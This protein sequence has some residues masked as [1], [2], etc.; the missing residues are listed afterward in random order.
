MVLAGTGLM[1]YNEVLVKVENVWRKFP[2]NLA[3]ARRHGLRE[4]FRNLVGLPTQNGQLCS[5]EFWVLKDVSFSLER[6]E[7]IGI[8]GLNGAGKSTLLKMIAGLL[9]PSK[10]EVRVRGK[11]DSLIEL[12]TGF[13]PSLSG[14]ENIFI[15]CAFNGMSHKETQLLFDEIV[16][17]AELEEFIDMP[18]KSYS[19]GM[20]ARLGF[21]TAIF[22]QPDILVIDEVLSVGDFAFRQ[23][24]LDKMN[25]IKERTAILFV[26]HSFGTVRMFCDKGIVLDRGVK[27]FEGSSKD[28]IDTLV[29]RRESSELAKKTQQK[30]QK[31]TTP[32]GHSVFGAVHKNSDKIADVHCAWVDD[33][34]NEVSE[35]FR[36]DK[37]NLRYRFRLSYTPKNLLIGIPLW[38]SKEEL[39]TSFSS[40]LQEHTFAIDSDG[41][42]RGR[43]G[44]KAGFNS[45]KYHAV[46]AIHDGPEYIYR[47]MLPPL[48]ITGQ[49]PR[50]FG[51][52]RLPHQWM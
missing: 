26:S 12:G 7:S 3:V 50:L 6:G 52:I 2:R 39:V 24:C 43:L 17:F 8:L 41:W 13:H 29:S 21:A 18:V 19:T 32:G 20:H 34:G 38:N 9:L 48:V 10:G 37:I 14:R 27:V 36:T 25:K 28:A 35:F 23:K 42:V 30:Q 31:Q 33:N 1:V 22:G 11:L 49:H 40:E 46:I 45:D 5:G 47:N 16:D 51:N 15:R 4:V 44:I